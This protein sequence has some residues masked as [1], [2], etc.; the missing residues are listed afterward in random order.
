M[1]SFEPSTAETTV[2]SID[3]LVDDIYALFQKDEG[4]ECNEEYLDQFANAIKDL[5][6]TRMA[7][8]KGKKGPVLRL[9]SIGKPICQLWH[10]ENKYDELEN[11]LS[12]PTLIKFMFGDI[13]E[14]LVILFAKEAGHKV[15]REQEAVHLGGVKGHIDCVIDGVV[16]DV[17][18]ASSYSFKKF[19]EGTLFDNDPFGYI[20]Q[21]TSYVR[22]TGLGQGAF[23]AMDKQLG[24]LALLRVDAPILEQYEPEARIEYV[25]TNIRST[26]AP[27]RQYEPVPDG[28]SGNLALNVNCSYCKAKQVCW[29][30]ANNGKGLRT[31]LY[32]TG[33]KFLVHVERE[34]NV[35][36]VGTRA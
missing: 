23:L 11:D 9:S 32:S 5:V 10:E 22:A 14:Q 19:T 25:K 6:R 12:S 17:K 24:K 20:G 31:F 1:K 26:N 3:T 8:K 16:V 15:E 4:H 28:K 13:I 36:E 30:D 7:Q 33:P 2:K 27:S 21:I 18:S 29:K 35:T 34:P